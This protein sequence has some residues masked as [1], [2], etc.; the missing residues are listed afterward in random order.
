MGEEIAGGAVAVG[1]SEMLD[2]EDNE[3][4]KAWERVE[5]VLVCTDEVVKVV[6]VENES[7][8]EDGDT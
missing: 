3:L 6:A 7:E 5:V 4:M 1:V 8:S 2:D